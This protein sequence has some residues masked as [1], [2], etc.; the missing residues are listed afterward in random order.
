MIL[1]SY[2]VEQMYTSNMS[3]K[4]RDL[5]TDNLKDTTWLGEVLNEDDPRKEGRLKV[6]V[7]GKFDLLEE[8]HIPWARAKNRITGGSDT[9][10]G[11]HSVAKKGSIVG[12]TFNNGNLHEPEWNIIQHISNELKDEISD[13]YKNAH[14]LIY[15]TITEGGLKIY[16][17][18]EKGL[19]FDYKKTQINIK[20]DNS[21]LIQNPNGDSV[22]LNND[23]ACIVNVSDK[24]D[25]TCKNATIKASKKVWI[26]SPTID[27]G[28]SAIEA[29]IKGNTFQTLFNSH[30]HVGNSG[31]NTSPPIIPLTGSELSTVTSTQ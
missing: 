30:V 22:E 20:T 1:V 13:N 10:S 3:I 28:K 8:N 15:D 6:K 12:I 31:V 2:Q 29:V 5:Y 24:I 17:T 27:L 9:G 26:D 23:G 25:V 4:E 16:F 7:F 21:I 18:E 14:S 19:M 11:F